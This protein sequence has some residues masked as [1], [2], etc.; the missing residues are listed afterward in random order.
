MTT[1]DIDI[2]RTV[3][4]WSRRHGN[5]AAG[6]ARK[7]AA[8]YEVAGDLDGADVWRRIG[9]ALDGEVRQRLVAIH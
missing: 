9:S 3:E 2:A 7:M 5:A 8:Q 4:L 1:Y 6:E